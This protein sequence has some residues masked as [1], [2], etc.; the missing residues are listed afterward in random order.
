MDKALRASTGTAGT[1]SPFLSELGTSHS[2]VLLVQSWTGLTPRRISAQE[3][4]ACDQ[5]LQVYTF[6]QYRDMS[7]YS[8]KR[9]CEAVPHFSISPFRAAA[10]R[11]RTRQDI[12]AWA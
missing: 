11:K 2:R 4:A 6:F 12:E 1:L 9:P 5:F 10:T 3:L 8:L 7:Y